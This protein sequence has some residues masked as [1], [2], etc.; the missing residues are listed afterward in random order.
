MA[1]LL[2]KYVHH[3]ELRFR[4]EP[5]EKKNEL[6]IP[7]GYLVRVYASYKNVQ[8]VEDNLRYETEFV[9]G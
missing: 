8:N 4:V 5:T 9:I 7:I 2:R 3:V 1:A 6:K